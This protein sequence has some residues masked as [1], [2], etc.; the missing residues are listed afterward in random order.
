MPSGS[1]EKWF[2]TACCHA[3]LAGLAKQNGPGASAAEAKTE[4]AQAMALLRRAVDAGY[5]RAAE[6]RTDSA[7]DPLRKRED[8]NK[9][10]EELEKPPPAKPE[11]KP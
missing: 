1:G 2:E 3:V 11:K 5:L 4:A 7:L 8:F 6:F 10:I 9:L